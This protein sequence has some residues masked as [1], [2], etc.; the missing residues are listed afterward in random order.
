MTSSTALDRERWLEANVDDGVC[1]PWPWAKTSA[2]YPVMRVDKKP[3]YVTHIVLTRTGRPWHPPLG[4]HVLHSCDNP[5]CLNPAHLSWGTNA[6]NRSESVDRGRHSRGEGHYAARLSD[7]EVLT[8]RHLV[9]DG[10]SQRSVAQAYGI[11]QSH[12]SRICSGKARLR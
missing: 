2:G 10:W 3:T 6:Q 4:N 7:E 9:G 1:R 12:V 5:P 8:I 11:D